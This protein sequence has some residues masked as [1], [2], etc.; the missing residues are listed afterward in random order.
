VPRSNDYNVGTEL[1]VYVVGTCLSSVFGPCTK[2]KIVRL[3]CFWALLKV[4]NEAIPTVPPK[5]QTEEWK[6]LKRSAKAASGTN[7]DT[8]QSGKH[9]GFRGG[10]GDGAG[11]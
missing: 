8:M 9:M 3:N 5:G 11:K 6:A 2:M 7:M 4:Q 10:N 1:I